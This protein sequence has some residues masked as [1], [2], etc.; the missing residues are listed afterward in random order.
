MPLYLVQH[1]KCLPREVDPDRPLSPEGK[2]EVRRIAGVAGGYGVNVSRI[3]HSGKMRARETAEILAGIL[4]PEDGMGETSGLDPLDDPADWAAAADPAGRLMLVGHLPF[5]ERLAALMV[6]G[7]PA[8]PV[9]RFQ[10]GGIVCLDIY[11]GTARDWVIQWA[12][13]PHVG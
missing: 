3:L 10:N 12:L 8:R 2:G 11:P 9:F 13:M 5:M 7:S 1:G 4:R 6:T